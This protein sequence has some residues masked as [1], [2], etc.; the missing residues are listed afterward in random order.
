LTLLLF[1]AFC[2]FTGDPGIS[3]GSKSRLTGG[4][5][6]SL[7]ALDKLASYKTVVKPLSCGGRNDVDG[8]DSK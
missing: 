2:F 3:Q 6:R 7:E 4:D 5:L 8:S 1:V